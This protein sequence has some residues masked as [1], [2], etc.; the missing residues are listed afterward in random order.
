MKRREFR[1]VK[2]EFDKLFWKWYDNTSTKAENKRLKELEQIIIKEN[3]KITFKVTQQYDIKV[4]KEDYKLFRVCLKCSRSAEIMIEAEYKEEAEE[5]VMD[6]I[7]EKGEECLT[8][9]DNFGEWI[10]NLVEEEQPYSR[11]KA[12]Q[13]KLELQI[14]FK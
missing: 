8:I 1:K 9:T 2:S 13:N 10:I 4:R 5:K 3:K 12:K 6:L 11:L 14:A 7:T